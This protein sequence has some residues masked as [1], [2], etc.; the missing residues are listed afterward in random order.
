MVTEPAPRYLLPLRCCDQD[1]AVVEWPHIYDGWSALW[2]RTCG[3]TIN[4]WPETDARH[5]RTEAAI[6]ELTR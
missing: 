2:C 4:R 5:A 1:M 3:R 6:Q